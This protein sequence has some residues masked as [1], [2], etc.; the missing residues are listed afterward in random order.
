MNI[1]YFVYDE[2][3][4][5]IKSLPSNR[6]APPLLSKTATIPQNEITDEIRAVFWGVKDIDTILAVFKCESG[7]N[8]KAISHTKDYG[9]AQ[10]NMKAHY[11]Q[12]AGETLDEKIANLLDYKYNIQFAKQLYDKNGLAP[13]VCYNKGIY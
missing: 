6:P 10:I 7:F 2:V 9:V 12:I 13:W 11:N 5:K 3:G 8:P 4:I 1:D